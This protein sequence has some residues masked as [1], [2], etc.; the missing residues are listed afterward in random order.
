MYCQHCGSKIYNESARFCPNCGSKL[1]LESEQEHQSAEEAQT[2]EL[3]EPELVNSPAVNSTEEQSRYTQIKRRRAGL[4]WPIAVPALSLIVAGGSSYAY[5]SHQKETNKS[6][7]S[8]KEK[9]EREALNGKYTEA[10]SSLKKAQTLRPTYKVLTED[11]EMIE[12]AVQVDKSLKEVT[13][14]LKTQKL[15]QADSQIN[16]LGITLQIL[17]GP[18][19][20]PLSKQLEEK[21]TT[22]AVAKIKIEINKLNTVE[23]LAGKLTALSSL[24]SAETEEVKRLI[25]AKVVELTTKKAEEQLG[26]KKF[27][28]ATATVDKGLEYAANDTKLVSFKTRI[29]N[30][31]AAFEKAEQERI[32]KAIEVAAQEDLNNHTAAV[33]VDN[34]DIYTDEYGDLHIAGD[35][36]NKA[37]VPISSIKIYYTVYDKDGNN[38]GS[39]YTYGDPYYL[40]P[41]QNGSFD[42]YH[43]GVYQDCTVKITRLTWELNE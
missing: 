1:A 21:S 22:L 7:I 6:V 31:Q 30:Q 24:N 20:T 41:G 38:L 34:L 12:K 28:E 5:Y 4:I 10:L 40:D 18:L 9:A 27:T 26:D 23:D 36:K 43:Y 13:N 17:K 16:K 14:S 39:D 2:Q 32:Q 11:K 8:L 3:A 25:T 29:E 37:T 33:S 35:L 42:D 15:D 19:Y